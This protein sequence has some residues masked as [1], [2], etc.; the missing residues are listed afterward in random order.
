MPLELIKEVNGVPEVELLSELSKVDFRS[1]QP[2]CDYS[3]KYIQVRIFI[4]Q[5]AF[6][7]PKGNAHFYV[8][9]IR[10]VLEVVL[11]VS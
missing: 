7:L 9:L 10:V 2:G 6:C 11:C 5:N 1:L 4:T 8:E 3:K